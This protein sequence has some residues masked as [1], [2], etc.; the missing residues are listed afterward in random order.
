MKFEIQTDNEESVD[1]LLLDVEEKTIVL[2]NDEVNTFDCVI[3]SL[4]KVCKHEPI[5]AEQCTILV[6]FKGRCDVKKGEYDTL[7]PICSALLERGLT[8]EI[9]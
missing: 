6:H 5:Q 2:Y 1:T 7:E 9:Q 8:A 3:D 4:I